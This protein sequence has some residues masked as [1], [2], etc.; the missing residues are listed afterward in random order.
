M[1]A[2]LH[3]LKTD[4]MS[5]V[6]PLRCNGALSPALRSPAAAASSLSAQHCRYPSNHLALYLWPFM[7]AYNSVSITLCCFYRKE[8]FPYAHPLCL[9]WSHI[10]TH[11]QSAWKSRETLF[12]VKSSVC[13]WGPCRRVR[14]PLSSQNGTGSFCIPS[15][16]PRNTLLI[17]Q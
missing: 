10:D 17:F 5:Q 16:A 13:P 12:P 7:A 9:P 14:G 3:I 1:G 11:C 8:T 15:P 2:L 4:P 6:I